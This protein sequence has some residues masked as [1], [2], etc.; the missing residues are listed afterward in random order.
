MDLCV[1]AA[2]LERFGIPPQIYVCAHKN[3]TGTGMFVSHAMMER[4]G[5]II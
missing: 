2:L 3:N 5:M 1:L 4:F